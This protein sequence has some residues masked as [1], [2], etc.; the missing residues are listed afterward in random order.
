[1]A[2]IY[3]SNCEPVMPEFVSKTAGAM[4]FVIMVLSRRSYE[5]FLAFLWLLN[6][7]KFKT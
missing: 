5:I 2:M 1:M 7:Q 3:F 6:R 4:S